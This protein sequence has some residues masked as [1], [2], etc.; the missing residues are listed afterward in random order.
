[1]CALFVEQICC[2]D[3]HCYLSNLIFKLQHKTVFNVP[4]LQ[5]MEERGL[6]LDVLAGK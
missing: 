3:I 2:R 4:E 1:M 6:E 5:M